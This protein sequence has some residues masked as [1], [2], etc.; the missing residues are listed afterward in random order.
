MLSIQWLQRKATV[1]RHDYPLDWCQHGGGACDMPYFHRRKLEVGEKVAG[2]RVKTSDKFELESEVT[3]RYGIPAIDIT[4]AME[5]FK[6]QY[7]VRAYF[8]YCSGTTDYDDIVAAEGE[9]IDMLKT[10]CARLCNNP[11]AEQEY[12]QVSEPF[13]CYK[14]CNLECEL[15]ITSKCDTIIRLP[16]NDGDSLFS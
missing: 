12:F 10:R 2:C 11:D 13:R 1:Y 16:D 15:L 7:V 6:P 3:D 9:S 8:N 4:D 14:L 5:R